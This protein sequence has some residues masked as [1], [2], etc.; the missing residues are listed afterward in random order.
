MVQTSKVYVIRCDFKIYFP[1]SDHVMSE[2]P[3]SIKD[4]VVIVG[5]D[6]DALQNCGLRPHVVQTSVHSEPFCSDRP[7][8]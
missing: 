6:K 8:V 4:H 1:P 2:A 3:K 5:D 7:T